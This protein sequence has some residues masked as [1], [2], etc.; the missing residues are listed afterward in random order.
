MFDASQIHFN[1][2]IGS[3]PCSQF[4]VSSETLIVSV[5]EHIE[6][7][8]DL[9]GVLLV[10]HGQ[11]V[12]LFSRDRFLELVGGRFGFALYERRAMEDIREKGAAPLIVSAEEPIRAIADRASRRTSEN[13]F[14]P[15]V[16]DFGEIGFFLLSANNLFLA[17][18]ALLAKANEE[19]SKQ[20]DAADSANE[21]K[22]QFLA[23]MSHEIRTP[24]NG[25]LGLTDLLLETELTKTQDDYLKMVKSSADWLIT[26]IN[27]V[28][29]FSKIEANMLSLE[30]IQFDIRAFLDDTMKPLEFRAKEKGLELNWRVDSEIPKS[31]IADPVRIRQI[32]VNLV[33][34][35]I[36]F[37]QQGHVTVTFSVADREDGCLNLRLTV[38]DS[39]VGIPADR[40]DKVFGAFEQA[41][42]TT[43]RE[44]GG[45]G[46]GLSICKRLAELMDGRAWAESVLGAG[47]SFHVQVKVKLPDLNEKRLRFDPGENDNQLTTIQSLRILLAEDNM[48]NQKL[49]QA[50]LAK[51]GHIVHTVP[52]GQQ[53]VDTALGSD[54]DLILMDV[55]MP[56]MDGMTATRAIR[57][58]WNRDTKIPI[59]AMT[60]H[61]MQGDREKCLQAGMD[62]YIAKPMN[63]DSL[64]CEIARVW[65]LEI[66][67]GK[68]PESTQAKPLEGIVDWTKS[69]ATTGG[70]E[71]ILKDIADEFIR[72]SQRLVDQI[73]SACESNDVETLKISAHSLK[74]SFGYFGIH[75]GAAACQTIESIATADSTTVSDELLLELRK[76]CDSACRELSQYV[77]YRQNTVS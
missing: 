43:T 31:V 77:K 9:P 51:S 8:H 59:I 24:M 3:L 5:S 72:D 32:L 7:N 26:V 73:F 61:A 44:F 4:T 38:Q 15:V 35:G 45:T 13:V 36:K 69:L 34:N 16:I 14:D 57:E 17:Q 20:K 55:Q 63:A 21:A 74:S 49:A 27:D 66:A 50:L 10:E 62:G 28:L 46:L 48:V 39:G 11:P 71:S 33:G 42:G 75:V 67:P 40:I 2:V 22:S 6:E 37:T 53:A 18:S 54:F 70:D 47:S 65:N 68:Q 64:H 1:S 12:S 23:N 19:V 30:A 29:D 56:I 76:A 58:R 41:D 60:A 25:I 52:D